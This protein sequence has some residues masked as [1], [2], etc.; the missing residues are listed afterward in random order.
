MWWRLAKATNQH[1]GLHRNLQHRI[2]N[3]KEEVRRKSKRQKKKIEN[4]AIGEV[5]PGHYYTHTGWEIRK[6]KVITSPPLQDKQK[7]Q[8][9]K[10]Q[11][12]KNESNIRSA[13]IRHVSTTPHE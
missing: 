3:V 5:G 2:P 4:R 8:M 12:E 10:T 9:G 1:P 11:N 7:E 6:T 13:P